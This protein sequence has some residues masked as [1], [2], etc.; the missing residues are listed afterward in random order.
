VT[1]V[2]AA[3]RQQRLLPVMALSCCSSGV[4]GWQVCKEMLLVV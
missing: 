2:T 4:R 3:K 1:P